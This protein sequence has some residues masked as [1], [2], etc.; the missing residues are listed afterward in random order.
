M[1]MTLVGCAV[2]LV[3]ICSAQ[4]LL[5]AYRAQ[6]PP[7]VDGVLDE[8][9]WTAASVTSPFISATG[10]GLPDEQ[11]IG[12]VCW[13][14]THIYIG[15]EAFEGFLAPDLNMLHAVKAE[16]NGEDAAVLSDD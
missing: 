6:T 7:A 3:C 9:C 11:T 14:A 13:D 8:A 10:P 16:R 4:P 2:V 15:V 12:R 1:R 5:T